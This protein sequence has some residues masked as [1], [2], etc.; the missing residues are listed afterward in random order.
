MR[1]FNT[2]R[3]GPKDGDDYVGGNYTT[4]I[5]IEAQLP[6]LLPEST[7]TDFSVFF[8]AGNVWSVDYSDTVGDSNKLRSAFGISANIFTPIGPLNFTLAQDLTK[9]DTDETESFRFNLGT[10][11]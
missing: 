4:A 11:F 7:K 1:G 3:T 5:G 2:R 6:N 10:T 8:D 9:A